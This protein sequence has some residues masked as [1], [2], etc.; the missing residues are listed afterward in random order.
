MSIRMCQT[1]YN[2]EVFNKYKKNKPKQ[3]IKEFETMVR[4]KNMVAVSKNVHKNT[5]DKHKKDIK[6]NVL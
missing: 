6:Y 4:K 2:E 1:S 3:C 5:S